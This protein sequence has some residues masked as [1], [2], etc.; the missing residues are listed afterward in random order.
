ME[1]IKC[2]R[3]SKRKN[4]I[5]GSKKILHK[6]EETEYYERIVWKDVSLGSYICYLQIIIAALFCKGGAK[7]RETGWNTSLVFYIFYGALK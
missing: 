2:I 5:G 6:L 7:N 4:K 3:C 1:L